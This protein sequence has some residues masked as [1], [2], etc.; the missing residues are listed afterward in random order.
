MQWGHVGTGKLKDLTRANFCR[1][2]NLRKHAHSAIAVI[3]L[4]HSPDRDTLLSTSYNH[5]KTQ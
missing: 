4:E 3:F 2:F 1:K 5:I